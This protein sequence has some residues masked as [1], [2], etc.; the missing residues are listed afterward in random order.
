MLYLME[1][2]PLEG[3]NRQA[4]E[5][6]ASRNSGKVNT[7]DLEEGVAVATGTARTGRCMLR[8]H[9]ADILQHSAV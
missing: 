5:E 7:F 8:C 4:V 9:T 2:V 3:V 1:H 6:E